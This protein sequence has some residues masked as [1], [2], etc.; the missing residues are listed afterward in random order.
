MLTYL[1]RAL[2]T[3]ILTHSDVMVFLM[4]LIH[5]S[6]NPDFLMLQPLIAL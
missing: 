1:F 6:L 3:F 2:I 5:H 4:V